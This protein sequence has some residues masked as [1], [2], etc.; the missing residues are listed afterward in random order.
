MRFLTILIIFSLF[1]IPASF[2][3][4]PKP[5]FDKPVKVDE[6]GRPIYNSWERYEYERKLRL[7][8]KNNGTNKKITNN[9]S[10]NPQ[11]PP[12]SPSTTIINRPIHLDK[13]N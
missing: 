5:L 9:A 8:R 10:G 12:P 3:G 1:Y 7:K 2:A 6:S 11:D 4:N 13:R